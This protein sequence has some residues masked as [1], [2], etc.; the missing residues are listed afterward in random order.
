MNLIIEFWTALNHGRYLQ[1]G[2]TR[3]INS[4][5]WLKKM[6]LINFLL[7]T[8]ITYDIAYDEITVSIQTDN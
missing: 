4:T 3:K 2:L 1:S 7:Y 5:Y 8:F 6:K